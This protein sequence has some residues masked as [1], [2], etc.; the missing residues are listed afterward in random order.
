MKKKQNKSHGASGLQIALA[1]ALVSVS[2]MLFASSITS[3]SISG[4]SQLAAIHPDTPL[5][6]VV[7]LVG[8]VAQNKDLRDLP[9]IPPNTEIE[10]KRLTRYPHPEIAAPTSQAD[11]PRFESLMKQVLPPTPKMPAPIL[12]FDGLNSVQSGCGCLPPDT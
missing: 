6:D 7:R 9:Y 1:L 10:E 8:P 12:T 2:A 5:P 4:P 11:Y 3:R